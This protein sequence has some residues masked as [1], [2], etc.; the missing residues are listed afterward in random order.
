M[1]AV[2]VG[3]GVG[4][5][6]SV[7]VAVVGVGVVFSVGVVVVRVLCCCCWRVPLMLVVVCWWCCL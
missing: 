1:F 5:L 2:D 7:T 6:T 4:R 3:G